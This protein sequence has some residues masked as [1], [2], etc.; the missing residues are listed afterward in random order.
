LLDSL[1]RLQADLI[2][3]KNKTIDTLSKNFIGMQGLYSQL[4][5]A[6]KPH[7]VVSGGFNIWTGGGQSGVGPTLQLTSKAGSSYQISLDYTTAKSG[8]INFTWL[9]PIRLKR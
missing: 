4:A 1:T 8:Y 3:S 9:S 5:L 6:S 2:A 7:T